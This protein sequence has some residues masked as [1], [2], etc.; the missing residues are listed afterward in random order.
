MFALTAVARPLRQH[1]AQGGF[2]IRSRRAP[3]VR[4]GWLDG[5][6][7]V[8][9]LLKRA[10]RAHESPRAARQF[11]AATAIEGTVINPIRMI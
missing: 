7:L 3:A 2:G 10:P 5:I 9:D 6:A 4:R 8:Y 11:G 1:G